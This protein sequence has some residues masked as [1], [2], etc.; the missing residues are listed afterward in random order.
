MNRLIEPLKGL[1]EYQELRERM[2]KTKGILS[3]TGCVEAQKAH[4]IYGLGFDVKKKV[5]V[6]ENDLAAKT[7]YENIRFYEPDAFLYPAKDLLFY[8]ADIASN[9]LDRLRVVVFRAL[10]EE[11]RVTVVLPVAALMDYVTK[12]T[13]F[14]ASAITIEID[15]DYDFDELKKNLVLLGYERCAAVEVPGQFSFRGDIVDIWEVTE[16][17]PVRIEFFG[18]NADSMRTFDPVTQRSVE[19]TDAITIY[20]ANDHTGD[21]AP[22][23][24][25]FDLLDTEIFLDEPNHLAEAAR[26]TEEEFRESVRRRAED[27][28]M[29]LDDMPQMSGFDELAA[30][31]GRCYCIALSMLPFRRDAW[32][33]VDTCSTTVQATGTYTNSVDLLLKD[34]ASYK[35][36]GYKVIV[37]SASHTRARRLANELDEDGIPAFYTEDTE[38]PLQNG[39]IAILYGRASRGFAYPLIKFAVIS[40]TDIFGEKKTRRKPKKQTLSGQKIASFT[41]LS[42]GDYVVHEDHGLGIYRGIER[43][44]VD[45]VLKD[46]IK[47]EYNGSN[48]YILATQ[49]DKLQKYASSESNAHPKLNKL[50]GQEWKKTKS[51]VSKSVKNIA[52][53]LVALYAAREQK[54]GFVYG[55]DTEWQREFE[56]L[57][58]YEETDDQLEAIEDTKKDMES[59]KIMDR[60]ICGDVGYGKT[61]IAIRAAFKAVQDGKQVAYLVPTTILAQQHYNTFSQRMMDFPV[62]V[63]M[64]SRFRTDSQQKKTIKDLKSGLVDI[65]IGTHRLLSKDIAFRNLGLLIIDE[66][67]RFGVAAKEKIKQMKKDVDV[68]TLTATPIP[69]TLHMSLIGIRDMSILDEPPQDRIAIQTYVMEFNPELVR[70][71]ICREIARH[72]QVYYVYNRVRDIA[73]TAK[74]VASLVPEATVAYADGQMD[75]SHLED[76]MVQFVNGEI[77]VLVTTTI[78]ETGLDIPNANTMIIQDADRMGLSQLY[79]LRGR[80]GRSNRTSYAFLMYKKDKMLKEVAEKR[81]SAIREFT[82]LGSGYKIAM[83]DLEIRGAGNLLGAEQSGHMESVGYDLYC[84]MLS[85]AVSEAK[86]ETSA[87]DFE[88]VV[89]LT[90]DAYIPDSYIPDEFQKLDFYKRI[91]A[92]ESE[93]DREDISDELMDRYGPLPRAVQNLCTV[94]TVKAMAHRVSVTELKEMGDMVRMTFLKEPH[95][96]VTALPPILAHFDGRITVKNYKG[97]SAFIYHK[98]NDGR[99]EMLEDVKTFLTQLA[100]T[101]K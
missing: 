61:E 59:T 5:I 100:Q 22:F 86:G 71:A 75:R 32:N 36:N 4:M 64:L 90:L 34:L 17:H 65:V 79:Q 27:E 69:R 91:A 92:I 58:P 97:G 73:D 6:A 46:Y 78:I 57:F 45:G 52:K 74:F 44:E 99:A 42:V 88:T 20:P 2:R 53:E 19:E 8:Q 29:S 95:F 33:L 50:G 63:D 23:I 21:L 38:T 3:L 18:E 39:Q 60:L 47:I 15:K 25:W 11:P 31:L 24:T 96:D 14:E 80:V 62:R 98:E 70:E 30:A 68:L 9:E 1:P 48:L 72:G 93:E 101:V 85:Q 83:R 89:D 28:S 76:I 87:E 49:L 77:D 56:E 51:Q 54:K 82:E 26:A 35:K 81:L 84:K 43:I 12:K 40:E 13:F 7:V 55:P 67:Q 37:L 41:D 16:D 66:E 94:A 10:I